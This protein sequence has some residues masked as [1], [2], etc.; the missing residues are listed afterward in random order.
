M[1]F[2]MPDKPTTERETRRI[3]TVSAVLPDGA[4]LE[5]VYDPA[6]RETAFVVARNGEG[7]REPF[8]TPAPGRRLPPDG[9]PDQPPP[10]GRLLLPAPT[11]GCRPRGRARGAR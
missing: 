5:M 6:R 9:P 4:L 3:P 7:T 11:G 10:N 1:I 2:T 8:V